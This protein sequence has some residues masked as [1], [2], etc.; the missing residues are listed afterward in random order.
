MIRN[1]FRVAALS[2]LLI[3]LPAAGLFAQEAKS[4]ID[5]GN[6]AWILMAAAL[7]LLMTVPGLALFYGGMVR[8]KN[9]LSTFYYSFI[10]AVIVSAL[11]V[12]FQ[13]SAA[14]GKDVGGIIGSLDKAFFNGIGNNSVYPGQTIPESV[15][16]AYQMMFAIITVAL[17]SGA[18]V[19]RMSFSAWIVFAAIWSSLIYAPLAHWVWGGGWMSHLGSLFGRPDIGVLDFAGGLVVH[20]SSGVSA[21]VA[22]L[23]LGKRDG[24]PHEAIL[25]SNIPF[26]FI[27]AGLLWFGWFGFNAGSAIMANGQAGSAFMVTNTSAVFGAITWIVLEWIINK[28]PSMIGGVSGLVAGLA[29]ITPASGFVSVQTALFVG[30]A[31]SIVS[32]FFVARVKAFFKYDDSLDAF[33]IHGVGG[34]LGILVTGLFAVPAI[35]GKAGLFSGEPVQFLVQLIA[36]LVG[37]A[38]AGVGTF[39]ILL[40]VD[41]VF[42][43]KVRVSVQAETAGLDI[44]H[45]GEKAESK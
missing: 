17:I 26:T 34:F 11:W 43:L 13:Y 23:Y 35:G 8:H 21:L 16:S 38:F 32:F 22:A 39:L 6:S 20:I 41:K 31:A 3:S 36:G 40:L 28:K 33:G 7:V 45:H 30:I 15:F 29:T 37:A 1:R 9:V 25:P 14:F 10:C 12:L 42:R 19:E 18:V 24:Y 44:S 4:A 5:S 27:G 2:A